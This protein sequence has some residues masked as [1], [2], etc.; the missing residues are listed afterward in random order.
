M[1]SNCT[2]TRKRLTVDIIDYE[3]CEKLGDRHTVNLFSYIL[4]N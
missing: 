4:F 3:I 2:L 1:L